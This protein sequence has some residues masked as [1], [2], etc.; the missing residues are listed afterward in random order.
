[1]PELLVS[2]DKR[3]LFRVPITRDIFRIGRGP[4]N[5]LALP[6]PDVSRQHA[7]ISFNGQAAILF[8][9]GA[10]GTLLDDELFV[11][12]TP[13]LDGQ[14]IQIGSWALLYKNEC[15][16]DTQRA[17]DLLTH[18]TAAREEV[19]RVLSHNP[20]AGTFLVET[21]FLVI[22]DGKSPA[23]KVPLTT[24]AIRIG[25]RGDCDIRLEDE[26]VSGQHC[27]ISRTPQGFVITDLQSTNGT[28]V[29]GNRIREMAVT[30]TTEITLGQSRLII[31][32]EPTEERPAPAPEENF[33]GLIGRSEKMRLLFTKIRKVALSDNTVLIWGETGTGKELVARAIHDLSPRA[34]EPYVVI[35]C[36]A[37]SAN[38]I[39]SELFGHEKGAFTGAQ[40]RHAGAFE[41][42]QGGTLFLDE[43]GELPLDLQP[44]LLRVLENRTIRRVGGDVDIPVNVKVIAAT[45][46]NLAEHVRQGKFREDLYFRLYILP[47]II[48]PLRHRPEDIALLAEHFTAQASADD[49]K[50][51]SPLALRRLSEHN[52]PG[53]VRELR[54]V[55][56]RSLVFCENRTI[57]EADIEWM[58]MGMNGEEGP[59]PIN[60]VE[61]EKDKI[62]EAVRSTGGNKSRAAEILGIA[63][64]TLFKKLK[65]F[66]IEET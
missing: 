61:V 52:W 6:D 34:Q 40:N 28:Y 44:K 11:G 36:G 31:D 60:L 65:E 48:P 32:W 5:D 13:L 17:R 10:N 3:F 50:I 54:N 58:E 8:G 24:P 20:D 64:S 62:L 55:I 15:S 1:M 33:C 41:Q 29:R 27:E 22:F 16:Q 66:G 57:D 18:I 37:I 56:L 49:P 38:L 45:H 25:T 12:P 43:V 21:P 51:L 42:A 2:K 53:N 23:H 39:E 30:R 9:L 59:E 4:G 19:T 47:L 14:Q 46:R 26:F 63:K 35:N 7:E